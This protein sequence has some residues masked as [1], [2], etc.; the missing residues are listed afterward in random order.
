[1]NAMET[2]SLI[3]GYNVTEIVNIKKFSSKVASITGYTGFLVAFINLLLFIVM[4]KLIY[5]KRNSFHIQ[6]LFV[7][8]TDGFGGFSLFLVSQIFVDNYSSLV[9]CAVVYKLIYTSACMSKGN[10][11]C[12]C[13]QRF[14]FSRRLGHAVPKW[15]IIH[16]VSLI[17]VNAFFGIAALV[18]TWPKIQVIDFEN[19]SQPCS[20][21]NLKFGTSKDLIVYCVLA[22]MSIVPSDVLCLLTI[23]TL[24]SSSSIVRPDNHTPVPNYSS[25]IS[26]DGV[27]NITRKKQHHAINTILMILVVF[28]LVSL[29]FI[30]A[31][32]FE[33]FGVHVTGSELR[34]CFLFDFV[35]HIVNPFL[36]ILRTRDLWIIVKEDALQLW[37][38][39]SVNYQNN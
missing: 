35:T 32:F 15:T 12:I 19:E 10:I 20:P 29:P 28:T 38:R 36:I 25:T 6:L 18:I 11:L 1:M 8:F 21:F 37:N 17:A 26:E 23:R 22:L 4:C 34:I 24:I 14:I 39:F 27:Q 7:A 5:K 9:T 2:T 16:V 31:S 3:D 33:V 13:F 30:I